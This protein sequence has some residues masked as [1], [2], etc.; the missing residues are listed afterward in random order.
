MYHTGLW[1]LA[2]I[3]I[4]LIWL[5][6]QKVQTWKSI[7]FLAILWSFLALTYESCYALFAAGVGMLFIYQYLFKK[8]NRNNSLDYVFASFLISIPIALLQG[9]AVLNILQGALARFT[10]SQALVSVHDQTTEV[11]SLNWPPTIFSST[12]GDLSIF[13]LHQLIVALLEIGP[14]LFFVPFIMKWAC[15]KITSGNW[16][17]GSIAGSSLLGFLA[18]IFL[19]YNPSRDA[20]TR[21]MEFSITFWYLFLIILLFDPEME[22]KRWVRILTIISL[23]MVSVSGFVNFFTQLSAIPKP[24]L[25]DHITGLDARISSEVWGTLPN[26]EIV[27]DPNALPGRASEVTGLPTVIWQYRQVLPFWEE[28]YENPSLA[29]I[30]QHQ[31]RYVY[32]DERWWTGLSEAEKDSLSNPCIKVVAESSTGNEFR[33]LLD[34]EQCT[35]TS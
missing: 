17:I 13:N 2:L 6:S 16:M 15:K 29:G 12:F 4:S 19:R 26:N 31:Y 9:G 23:V 1:P 33:R 5:L 14:I 11:F 21:L 35:S 24:V 27:F 28:L 18:A 22:L 10:G 32:I 34:L 8:Q 3:T 7:P 20:I 25:S 30:L